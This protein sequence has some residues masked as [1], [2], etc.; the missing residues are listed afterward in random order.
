MPGS[1]TTAFILYGTVLLEIGAAAGI[2]APSRAG[3]RL[4]LASFVRALQR[5]TPARSLFEPKGKR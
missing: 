5:R 1:I 3:L 2:V 4:R